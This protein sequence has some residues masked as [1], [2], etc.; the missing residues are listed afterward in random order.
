M[1]VIKLCWFILLF[2]MSQEKYWYT[3][4]QAV[5]PA[6]KVAIYNVQKE[7]SFKIVAR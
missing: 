5:I 6:N 7:S 3:G 2:T 4:V 1:N